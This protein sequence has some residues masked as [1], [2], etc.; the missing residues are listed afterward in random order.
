MGGGMRCDTRLDCAELHVLRANTLRL[1]T[2]SR[3]HNQ[4]EEAAIPK[5]DRPKERALS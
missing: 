1:P 5:D 2:Q 3:E 4:R